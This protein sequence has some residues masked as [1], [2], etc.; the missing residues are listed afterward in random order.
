MTKPTPTTMSYSYN[1]LRL[2]SYQPKHEEVT[3]ELQYPP[4]PEESTSA[5]STLSLPTPREEEFNQP[6]VRRQNLQQL[7]T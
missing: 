6:L 3:P 2:V 4:T 7:A 5:P 1:F